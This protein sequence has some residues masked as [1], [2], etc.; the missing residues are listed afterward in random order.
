MKTFVVPTREEVTEANQK[1][2]DQ[3]KAGL[4]FVPNLYA[5]FGKSTFGLQNYL[6]FQNA[7][8]SLSGKEREAIN[9][10]VS[11]FNNCQYCLSAHT[12]IGKMKGF[13]SGQIMD[14]RRSTDNFDLKLRALCRF[15]KS[16]VETYGR[17]DKQI[18]ETFFSVGYTEE[19]M[20]DV[21]MV[22]GD[23]IISNYLHGITQI[24]IDF[25]PAAPL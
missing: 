6:A 22:I 16:V 19:N 8:S 7:K 4:G 24:P 1:V 23:K 3:L 12:T 10:V 21:L 15:V 11:Q 14:I 13:T 17:P 2:F 25:E 20:I 9:L 18:L 5:M